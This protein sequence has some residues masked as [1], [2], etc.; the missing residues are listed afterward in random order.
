MKEKLISLLSVLSPGGWI[1]CTLAVVSTVV[2]FF[3]PVSH[4]AGLLFWTFARPHKQMYDPVTE[5][6]NASQT[7]S[8]SRVNILLLSGD[9]LQRRLLSGFLSGTPLPDLVEVYDSIASQAFKGRQQDI[10][11]ADLT[12]RLKQDGIIDRINPP[13]FSPWTSRGRIYGLPH[14]VHPVLLAYRADIIEAAGIDMTSIETW[15][16]F[17]RVLRPLV[18]DVD[19]DG[20]IDHYL[21][22]IWETNPEL[23]EMLILQAG[24][25]FFDPDLKLIMDSE[26]NARVLATVV[27]W[28]SGPKRIAVNAPEFD[29]AGNRMRIEGYVLCSF[30]PDWLSGVW[31]H[32]LPQLK[33]KIKLMPLPAWSKGGRRT[34]V[35]GGTM[36]GIP[37]NS[38]NFEESWAYA[39]KLYFTRGIAHELYR[40]AGIIT[41][42]KEFWGDDIYKDPN[43]YFS[44]QANGQLYIQ[45]APQVP[46]RTS[47]PYN[48]LAV[49]KVGDCAMGLKSYAARKKIYSVEELMPQAKLL[50][51]KAEAEVRKQMERNVF[52]AEEGTE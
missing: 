39:K 50:L 23:I 16:D 49:T 18:N 29:A 4:P 38:G 19:G 30:L 45:Q 27:S 44:G 42:V 35:M 1:I 52:L 3:M 15:D 36:L 28:T 17:E 48:S 26:I 2:L 13:S 20:Y 32:D 6:W 47:S 37:K 51:K 25:G 7:N 8:G 14:D 5:R 10:G 31:Q 43:Q 21:L 33:G 12:D 40:E 11:F 22:N 34:S 9:A 41:P 24:G 46:L